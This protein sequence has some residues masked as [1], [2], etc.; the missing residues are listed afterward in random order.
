MSK[1]VL[2]GRFVVQSSVKGPDALLSR[3]NSF[4]LFARDNKIANLTDDEVELSKRALI[5]SLLQKDLKLS[6]EVGRLWSA[7]IDESGL[8]EFDRKEKKIAAVEK[9]NKE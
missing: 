4:L 8:C 2:H 9:V 1:K 6:H 3:I 7:I 5:K